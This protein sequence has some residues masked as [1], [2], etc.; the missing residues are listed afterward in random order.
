MKWRYGLATAAV[1]ASAA[2]VSGCVDKERMQVLEKENADLRIEVET[3]RMQ[4]SASIEDGNRIAALEQTN[5]VLRAELAAAKRPA[6]SS[7]SASKTSATKTSSSA[8]K[9]SAPKK[10]TAKR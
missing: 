7:S 5:A 2:L 10:T 1:C 4:V 3:L 9:T 8:S 6:V